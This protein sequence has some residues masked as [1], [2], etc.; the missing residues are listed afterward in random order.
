LIFPLA[1]GA[2][3]CTCT[4]ALRQLALRLWYRLNSRSVQLD[5]LTVGRLWCTWVHAVVDPL[6]ELLPRPGRD[7]L[8][9][10]LSGGKND[11]TF[12]IAHS[13][14]TKAPHQPPPQLV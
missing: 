14:R 5:V 12:D 4:A 11:P 13:C 10:D 3:M 7:R 8:R 6:M 1:S 9:A 2:L